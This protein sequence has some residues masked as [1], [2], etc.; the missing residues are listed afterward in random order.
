M[1]S[2]LIIIAT[3]LL[4]STFSAARAQTPCGNDGP[5][6][7]R[8]TSSQAT[9]KQT[10][11]PVT[12]KAIANAAALQSDHYGDSPFSLPDEADGSDTYFVV[13]AGGGLDTG[14]TFRAKGRSS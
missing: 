5:P 11:S 8:C 14:C 4:I 2:P 1:K 12:V 3:L 13:D 10:T 7:Q 9:A 6:D